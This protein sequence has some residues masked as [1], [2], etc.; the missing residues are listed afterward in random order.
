MY[1][2]E[3][4]DRIDIA[5]HGYCYTF[6]KVWNWPFQITTKIYLRS[7]NNCQIRFWPGIKMF[8]V[9]D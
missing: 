6:A 1:K 2:L 4:L 3:L 7:N 5:G 8:G 9:K